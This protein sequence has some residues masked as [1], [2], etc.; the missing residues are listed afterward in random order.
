MSLP[1][2]SV[3]YI[4][5]KQTSN[6]FILATDLTTSFFPAVSSIPLSPIAI[7]SHSPPPLLYTHPQGKTHLQWTSKIS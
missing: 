4:T 5:S 7:T 2:K 6:T 1:G 3:N